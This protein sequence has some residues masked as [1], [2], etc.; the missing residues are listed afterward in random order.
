LY[1]ARYESTLNARSENAA[2]KSGAQF[3]RLTR[4]CEK[5]AQ[6]CTTSGPSSQRFGKATNSPAILM[7]A[8]ITD[9]YAA[10]RIPV[11]RSAVPLPNP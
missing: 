3:H 1:L 11:G 10:D 4:C 9:I 5:A 7:M 8:A 6:N 2:S